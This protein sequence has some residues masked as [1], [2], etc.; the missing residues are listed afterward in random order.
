MAGQLP[1]AEDL[2]TLNKALPGC[3]IIEEVKSR[4]QFSGSTQELFE[5]A[6]REYHGCVDAKIWAEKALLEYAITGKVPLEV[7]RCLLPDCPQIKG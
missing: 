1:L 3:R 2:A 7:A 5:L 6:Y 4:L